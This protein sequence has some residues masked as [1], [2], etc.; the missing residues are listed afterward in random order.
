M[1]RWKDNIKVGFNEIGWV[2]M[3]GIKLAKDRDKFQARVNTVMNIL[4]P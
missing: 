1:Y 4:V 3:D 2:C